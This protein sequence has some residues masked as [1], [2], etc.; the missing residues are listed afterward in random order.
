MMTSPSATVTPR[1]MP[2]TVALI[3]CSIFIASI[4]ATCWPAWTV[5]PSATS[6]DTT[7]PWMGAGNPTEPSGPVR[8]GAEASAVAAWAC[9][10][11]R[12]CS[13]SASGSRLSIC[14]PAKPAPPPPLATG[15]ALTTKRWRSPLA[16]AAVARASAWWSRNRVYMRP[17]A[18]SGWASTARRK[19]MF[20]C[21]PS[22]R[23]SD[24][25]RALR[26]TASPKSPEGE[27]VITL[28]SSESKLGL[29][30]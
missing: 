1:T 18:K 3:T 7:V 21:T 30:R 19:G 22:M 11:V 17:A 2:E 4:T 27:C 5:S 23:N 26:A 14:A 24:S 12:S 25:A 9:L 16:A 20:V 29:V 8:S 10:T 15:G 6:T 28:A 13:N